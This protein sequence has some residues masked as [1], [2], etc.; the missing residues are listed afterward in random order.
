MTSFLIEIFQHLLEKDSYGY[1]KI[2]SFFAF[3]NFKFF[4]FYLEIIGKV[5]LKM[6]ECNKE[7]INSELTKNKTFFL[8]VSQILYGFEDTCTLVP[9]SITQILNKVLEFIPIL[10]QFL[11]EF[12]LLHVYTYCNIEEFLFESDEKIWEELDSLSRTYS[13]KNGGFL[14]AIT[15]ILF[16]ALFGSMDSE[17]NAVKILKSI[18][19]IIFYNSKPQSFEKKLC[20]LYENPIY[21]KLKKI[22]ESISYF[23]GKKHSFNEMFSTVRIIL[24]S[25]LSKNK[26]F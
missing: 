14:L 1:F 5:F 4:D 11:N 20:F 3:S 13:Y 21:E 22:I 9:S 10:V 24:I 17:E 7:K 19:M 6:I 8:N 16:F 12:N 2:Y 23:S 15:N 26:I 18:G 25:N